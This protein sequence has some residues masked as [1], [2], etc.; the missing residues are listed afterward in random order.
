M[1]Y[2]CASVDVKTG[3]H[4]YPIDMSDMIAFDGGLSARTGGWAAR[5]AVA[6]AK[7]ARP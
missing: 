6:V 5:L 2:R 7:G 3:N 4:A 1:Q